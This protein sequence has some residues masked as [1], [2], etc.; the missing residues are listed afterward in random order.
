VNQPEWLGGSPIL[1]EK[2]EAQLPLTDIAQAALL[3]ASDFV[4]TTGFLDS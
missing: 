1:Q 2:R 3:S 4:I